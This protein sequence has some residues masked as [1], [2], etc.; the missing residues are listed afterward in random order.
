MCSGKV[1]Y[2]TF[3]K[4]ATR[5]DEAAASEANVLMN[6]WPDRA[7]VDQGHFF[8]DL[9]GSNFAPPVLNSVLKYNVLLIAII[10]HST[11]KK[12]NPTPLGGATLVLGFVVPPK[13]NTSLVAVHLI[14]SPTAVKVLKQRYQGI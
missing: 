4:G 12:G 14:H 10:F 11:E 7:V 13:C 1:F 8:E 6:Q 3:N 5:E 9:F 2:F